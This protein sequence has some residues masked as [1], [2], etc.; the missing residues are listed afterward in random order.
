MNKSPFVVV[1]ASNEDSVKMFQPLN[2]LSTFLTE[3]RLPARAPSNS[4]NTG[5]LLR[6]AFSENLTC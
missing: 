3:P 5:T 1:V 6:P 2:T 4:V